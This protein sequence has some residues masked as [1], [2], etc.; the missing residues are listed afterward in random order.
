[1]QIQKISKQATKNAHEN[2]VKGRTLIKAA[3]YLTQTFLVPQQFP[4]SSNSI[5]EL[6]KME[7]P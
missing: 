7:E 4:F 1:M 5:R 3:E 2:T 6:L